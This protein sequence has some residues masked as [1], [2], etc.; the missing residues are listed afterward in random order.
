MA[1]LPPIEHHLRVART[2]R[3]ITIGNAASARQ[4]WIVCHGYRQLAGRFASYFAAIDDGSTYVVA[5]EALS[6]FYL[7][8]GQ[9]PHA[10][11]TDV[12]ASWMTREDRSSE[13]TDYV[14]YLDAVH[15]RIFE[16]VT[17]SEVVLRVLG[18]SQG[19]ETVC[20][21]VDRG[22]ARP[23]HVILWGGFVPDDVAVSGTTFGKA[24]VTVVVGESD[25][26]V[27]ASRLQYIE[28]RLQDRAHEVVRFDG[29]HHL[30]KNVLSQ[31]ATMPV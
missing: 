6:R 1:A 15:D 18:F 16:D 17:R 25:E 30:N 24:K 12:G 22:R 14:E 31:L 27:T 5:P 10:P 13:I 3:Y 29:G 7:Y 2:A 23:D 20:R 19:V 8:D 21:W 28:S 26:I 9:G 4:V 11:E